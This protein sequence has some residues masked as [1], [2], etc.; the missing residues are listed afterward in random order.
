MKLVLVLN[1][2]QTRKTL[3][4]AAKLTALLKRICNADYGCSQII[5]SSQRVDWASRSV[6]QWLRVTHRL[7]MSSE[8]EQERR[9]LIALWEIP[10]AKNDVF[11]PSNGRLETGDVTEA[12]MRIRRFRQR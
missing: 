1:Y 12:S 11:N 7:D 5:Y 8:S 10:A 4:I 6:T 2:D 9:H 3:T